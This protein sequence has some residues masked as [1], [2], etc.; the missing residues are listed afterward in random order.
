MTQPNS[1]YM[2]RMEWNETEW[3]GMEQNAWNRRLFVQGS[4]SI[5]YRSPK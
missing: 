4:Q 1:R 5:K 3:N 2:Y